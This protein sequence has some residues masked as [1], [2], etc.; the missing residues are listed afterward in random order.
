VPNGTAA[1][2][3]RLQELE[4]EAVVLRRQLVAIDAAVDP[5]ESTEVKGAD[6]RALATTCLRGGSTAPKKAF[7]RAAVARCSVHPGGMT[8]SLRVPSSNPNLQ[9]QVR[10]PTTLVELGGIE[11]P[12]ISP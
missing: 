6:W 4:D 5:D 12:S 9:T 1:A 7:V 8:I 11:P 2:G 3:E 10:E